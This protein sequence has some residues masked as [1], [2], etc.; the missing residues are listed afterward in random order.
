VTILDT[1]DI[2]NQTASAL[3]YLGLLNVVIAVL[4]TIISFF[5]LLISLIKNIKDNIWEL[6]IL[7][8]MGLN[9]NQIYVI[10]FV[11]TFSVILSAL[12]LGTS[13]GLVT[14]IAGT[15][16]YIIFFELPFMFYFPV[17]EFCMLL[18]FMIGTSFLTTYVGLKG[19]VYQPISKILKGLL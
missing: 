18:F 6:G 7:R 15:I 9:V 12:L 3:F 8:S 19:I 10:Y 16:Y 1:F 17:S 4:T 13:V 5:M 14:S 11:E 2:K